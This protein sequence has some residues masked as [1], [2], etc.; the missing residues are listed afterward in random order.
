M[1]G[2]YFEFQDY[3]IDY[4]GGGYYLFTNTGQKKIID[5]GNSVPIMRPSM[6]NLIAK[7]GSLTLYVSSEAPNLASDSN[8]SLTVKSYPFIFEQNRVVLGEP[9][10]ITKKLLSIKYFTASVHSISYFPKK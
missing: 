1:Y 5:F 8:P 3:K 6:A 10:N 4:S 2:K 7:N 9:T